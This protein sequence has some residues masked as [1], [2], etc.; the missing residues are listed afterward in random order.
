MFD[1]ESILLYYIRYIYLIMSRKLMFLL[2][3][4]NYITFMCVFY[5]YTDMF[6]M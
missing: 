6:Y 2:D 3:M 1:H 4:Y 5:Y